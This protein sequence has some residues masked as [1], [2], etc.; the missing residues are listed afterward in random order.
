MQK[1]VT[2]IFGT[3]LEVDA[4]LNSFKDDLI[5][6]VG[7]AVEANPNDGAAEGYLWITVKILPIIS[8][9]THARD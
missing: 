1:F 4:W 6:I 2:K 8:S 9:T 5:E 3:S 7:Y